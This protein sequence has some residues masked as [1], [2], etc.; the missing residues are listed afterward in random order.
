MKK[1]NLR[2]FPY[3]NQM[4]IMIITILNSHKD[5]DIP[6][7][8]RLID[9]PVLLGPNEELPKTV[10]KAIKSS[11]FDHILNKSSTI[12]IWPLFEFT[13]SFVPVIV[14]TIYMKLLSR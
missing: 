12:M 3:N 5:P 14:I 13:F 4:K 11:V 7:N 6:Q 1:I 10:R 8:T 2:V 9:N